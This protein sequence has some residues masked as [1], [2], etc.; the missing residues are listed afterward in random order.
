MEYRTFGQTEMQL[1]TVALGGLPARYEELCGQPQPEEK[2]RVYLR[3]AELG[4]SL[5]D[6]GYGD[7]VYI[8]DEPKGN[9]GGR[10]FSLKVGG[11]RST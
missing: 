7:E 5:F 10:C 8:P 6:M 3:A 4:I 1:S 2:G 9:H 11:P